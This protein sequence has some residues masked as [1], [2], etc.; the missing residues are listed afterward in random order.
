MDE[1]VRE[2]FASFYTEHA[3]FLRHTLARRGVRAADL[4]DVSQEAFVAAHRNL[5]AF[6]GRSSL[7]TWLTAIAWR[8]ASSYHKR[9]QRHCAVDL[10]DTQQVSDLAANNAFNADDLAAAC[11]ALEP[12]LRDLILLHDIGGLNV[13]ELSSL[14]GRARATIRQ[15]LKKARARLARGHQPS[16]LDYDANANAHVAP[17]PEQRQPPILQVLPSKHVVSSIAG[18]LI[19]LRSGVTS[20]EDIRR[21][22]DTM[23]AMLSVYPEGF[24]YLLVLE[25]SSAPPSV[26]GRHVNAELARRFGAKFH[27]VAFAVESSTLMRLVGPILNSYLAL[28]RTPLNLR[29]FNGVGPATQWLARDRDEHAAL[30][31]HVAVMRALTLERS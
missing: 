20:A 1:P 27:A 7:R 17:A 30:M 24:R 8:T 25:A 26:E 9:S 3:S 16:T 12:E 10:H 19:H 15:R 11:Q 28:A 14:T 5:P 31:E 2:D 6:E 22:G 18:V 21:G 29:F 13:S 23:E 4:D